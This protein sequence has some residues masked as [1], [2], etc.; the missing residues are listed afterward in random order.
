M[1]ACLHAVV[2][3]F[4]ERR[5]LRDDALVGVESKEARA[6]AASKLRQRLLEPV[7]GRPIAREHVRRDRHIFDGSCLTIAQA[8]V[9]AHIGSRSVFFTSCTSRSR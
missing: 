7:I 1:E 6:S 4:E 8:E 2:T 9:A 5:E 3:S